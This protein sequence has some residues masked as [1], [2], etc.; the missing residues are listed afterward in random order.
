MRLFIYLVTCLSS[1]I[2]SVGVANACSFAPI[3][4]TKDQHISDMPEIFYGRAIQTIID[5]KESPSSSQRLLTT[6]DVIYSWK[7]DPA[8]QVAIFHSNV[9]NSTCSGIMFIQGGNY[10]VFA[11]PA[12][13]G[14]LMT[15]WIDGTQAVSR[16]KFDYHFEANNKHPTRHLKSLYNPPVTISTIY[17]RKMFN[18]DFF[19]NKN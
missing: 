7:G 19:S 15:D 8:K 10:L 16:S 14:R 12:Q 4:D 9:T 5:H 18:Q 11:N 2:I 6:F 17:K 13:D 1:A 3:Y